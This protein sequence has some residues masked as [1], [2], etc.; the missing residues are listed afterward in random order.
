MNSHGNSRRP[1]PDHN[2]WP[3]FALPWN[4]TSTGPTDMSF[5]L[6][7]P[8][9]K[10]GFIQIA[11]G[12]LATGDGE[13]WRIWG[14]NLCFGAALPPME[15]APII[16]R[17]MAKY[18]I[19]C[20][21]LH[22]MDH[23]WPRG[24]LM[25]RLKAQPT[26]SGQSTRELDP[27]ALA[28]LDYLIH[29]CKENGIYINVN[30][31]VSRPFTEADGVKQVEWIGYGKAL[32]YFDPQ[33]IKLQKEYAEQLL[34]HV[35]P[36]TGVRYADEPAVAIVEIV[37]ENSLL[38]SWQKGR[39]RGEQTE[40]AGTFADIPPTYAN[41]LQ[42]MWNDWLEHRYGS[43]ET[44]M[45]VWKGDLQDDEDPSENTVRR[46]VPEEFDQAAD[47]RFQD[48][49]MFYAEL[50]RSFFKDM[51]RFLRNDI[52]VKQLIVG[53][54]DWDHSIN[55]QLAVENNTLLDVMDGHSYWQHPHFPGAAWSRTE[56]TITNTPM[57]DEP[58]HSAPARLS[59]TAVKGMPYIVSEVNAPFPNDY[60]TE[61][62]PI[63]TS[64]A[65]LQD[66]DGIFMF[67][68]GG[69]SQEGNWTD[70]AIRSYFDMKNDPVKMAETALAALIFCRGD[71]QSAERT[72]ERHLTRERVLESQR[73]YR[74]DDR[75][76]YALP[77]LLGRLALVHKTRLADFHA[78][79]LQPAEGEIDL[80]EGGIVSDTGELTWELSDDEGC[81][82]IDTPRYQA[83]IGRAGARS[84]SG[85]TFDLSTPFA[86]VQIASLDEH[87]IAKADRLLLVTTA[88]VANTDM[89]WL[90]ATRRS[91]GASWG[92]EPTRIEPVVGS[93]TLHGRPDAVSVILR[94]LDERGQPG[95]DGLPFQ[96]AGEGWRIE[97]TEDLGT[98]W[99]TVEFE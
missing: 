51:C 52:G 24:V 30:L 53:T 45:E 38:D 1:M 89:E 43:R 59:R 22:H 60:A 28:R 86:A 15:M 34:E 82:R 19:N 47:R 3:A 29:C 79:G 69:G 85:M 94:P 46:L 95:D 26:E 98:V 73:R 8:A 64:Y 74:P 63:L 20:V 35:N 83:I 87:P 17:R 42:R 56:W 16:A 84:T 7:K 61:Y 4:D 67:A 78:D 36:F 5:L 96:K 27:E 25:R 13:R 71:V 70:G 31:N 92:Q 9:G 55:R 75:H 88:Q 93:L 23:R 21:R 41:D 57:V 99:Y 50:E 48:E 33:L 37:N 80:P 66:W 18:G 49:A 76:P 39:L 40:P 68:Y 90:D 14:Q 44:L 2:E 77:Y 97:L 58:D 62:I 10:D 91:L 72:V 12:H 54:S 6:H 32:T 81:V 65:L 11:D